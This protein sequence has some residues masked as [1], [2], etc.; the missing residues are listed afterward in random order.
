MVDTYDG[1]VVFGQ[2]VSVN[3]GFGFIQPYREKEQAYYNQ[4]GGKQSLLIIAEL[5]EFLLTY[6]LAHSAYTYCRN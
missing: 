2:V 1:D 3:Q 4:R 6:S 5:P